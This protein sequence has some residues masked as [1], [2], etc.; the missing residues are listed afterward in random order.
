MWIYFREANHKTTSSALESPTFQG[1][2]HETSCRGSVH[3]GWWHL[4][5]AAE[6]PALWLTALPI[7]VLPI[8]W[9]K[10]QCPLRLS[11]SPVQSL[12]LCLNN[13]SSSWHLLGMSG[14]WQ[15]GGCLVQLVS[16]SWSSSFLS[17]LEPQV[18]VPFSIH[19][20]GLRWSHGNNKNIMYVL[21]SR[22]SFHYYYRRNFNGPACLVVSY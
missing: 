22:R 17:C 4:P 20:H 3:L 2:N 18:V 15:S 13:K 14:C 10:I 12:Y 16:G 19:P 6:V 8:D 21:T 1:E 11:M 7:H 9:S 5:I